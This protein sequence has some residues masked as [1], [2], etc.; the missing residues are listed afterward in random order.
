MAAEGISAEKNNVSSEYK[1][2]NANP[3]G[4][5]PIR[6]CEPKRFPRIMSEEDD[7]GQSKVKKVS[8]HVLNY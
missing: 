2:A 5:A 8:M 4:C 6:I 3:K 7:E 1:R